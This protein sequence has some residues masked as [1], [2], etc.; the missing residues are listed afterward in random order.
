MILNA[1]DSENLAT[2]H[3]FNTVGH[4]QVT[5]DCLFHKNHFVIFVLAF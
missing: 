5:A 4:S 1:T 2:L 3:T